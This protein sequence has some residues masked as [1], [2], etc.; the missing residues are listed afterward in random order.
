MFRPDSSLQSDTV[1]A[2]VIISTLGFAAGGIAE[3]LNWAVRWC[4]DA[5][6][7]PVVAYYLPHSIRP[8][9][10]VPAHRLL[11]NSVRSERKFVDG[12]EQ[13]AIGA[14]LP[15]CE[16]SHYWATTPWRRLIDS[17]SLYLSVSGNCLPAMPFMQ[18]DRPYLSWV[19]SGWWQDREHRAADFSPLRRMFDRLVNQTVVPSL[20]RRIL[21]HG[22]I[23]ATSRYTEQSLHQIAR[24][25]VDTSIVPVPI[26][27]TEYVPDP[28][29]PVAARIGFSGRFDDPRKHVGLLLE[30]VGICAQ[31]C[32]Q[33]ELELIGAEPT[34]ELTRLAS[35]L[36]DRV[37]FCGHL[38]KP[39]LIKRL[40]RLDLFV[41]PSY[42][43]GLCISALQA[44]AC[45]CPVV[46]T[47][48]GGPEDYVINN[49][50]G[51]LVDADAG[52]MA[53]AILSLLENPDKRAEM[54]LAARDLVYD[55]FRAEVAR[56]RFLNQLHRIFPASDNGRA[57]DV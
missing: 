51:L 44:M 30:A 13:H 39:E 26:D 32:P 4:M 24:R 15:E 1:G 7:T 54:G 8:G 28:S 37:R 9:L 57:I 48:C 43:E 50:T 29:G 21:A 38:P 19:A 17:A 55:S 23:L 12:I 46:S 36:H 11:R 5:G 33:V 6:Y 20:E 45:G 3:T 22:A 49:K 47:R 14:W 2:R 35:G 56:A 16:F 53:A 27:C 31:R 34:P 40:Q 25:P 10:S 41:V 42:Q 52:H 18:S